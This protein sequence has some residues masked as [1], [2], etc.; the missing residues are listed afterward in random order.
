MTT[1]ITVHMAGHNVLIRT[2]DRYA[3]SKTVG[4]QI[5]RIGEEPPNHLYATTTRTI[6][7]VDLEPD[8]PRLTE[9]LG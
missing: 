8:D 6:E 1:K 2:I 9:G 7:V 4:E 3:T 5:V